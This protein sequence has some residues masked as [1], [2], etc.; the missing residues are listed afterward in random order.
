MFLLAELK[1]LF[2]IKIQ[3]GNIIALGSVFSYS[4][5]SDTGSASS[6]DG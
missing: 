1:A 4:G 2:F 6:D 5:G 3:Q